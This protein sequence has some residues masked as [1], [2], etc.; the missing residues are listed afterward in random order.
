MTR[1]IDII[2]G[3]SMLG[4]G[5]RGARGLVA[6]GPGGVGILKFGGVELYTKSQQPEKVTAALYN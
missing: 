4:P 1:T 2:H 6:G 3:I 5:G